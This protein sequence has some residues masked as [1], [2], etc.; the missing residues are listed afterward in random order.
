[1]AEKNKNGSACLAGLQQEKGRLCEESG[2]FG[3]SKTHIHTR[4]HIYMHTSME[5]HIHTYI[6]FSHF[7][8]VACK[9]SINLHIQMRISMTLSINVYGGM[10]TNS[11]QS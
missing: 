7:V 11:M 8:C 5:K 10:Y 3:P 2:K 1:M 4:H 9:Q 6:L